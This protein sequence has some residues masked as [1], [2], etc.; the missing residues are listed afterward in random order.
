MDSS[1]ADPPGLTELQKLVLRA[2]F[3]R[4]GGFYLT[5]G[6]ALVGFHLRHRAT[7]D[8]D[9]FTLDASA[10]ERARHVLDDLVVEIGATLQIVQDAPG[11]VRAVVTKG[12]RALVV[13]LVRDR[14]FQLHVEKPTID[15][16]RVDPADEILANKITALVGRAEERDLVDVFMLERTGLRVE[17]AL[18]TALAKDGGCT[19][20]NLAWLLSEI[21]IPDE[22]NLPGGVKAAELRAWLDE[23]IVR[24]RRA[25]L[26]N[27]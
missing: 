1:P 16:I 10:F 2:F 3:A 15:G 9:L 8:L 12:E 7:T 19:P 4:E 23:L 25:A 6:A 17:D 21:R 27:A 24:L 22:A 13:D 14:S 11:F 20:A 26:P 18:A 5:G